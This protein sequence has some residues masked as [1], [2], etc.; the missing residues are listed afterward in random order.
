MKHQR[1]AFPDPWNEFFRYANDAFV[2]MNKELMRNTPEY[3][4]ALKAAVAARKQ[5]AKEEIRAELFKSEPFR[6]EVER[7]LIKE[8][9]EEQRK[10]V[11]AR[12]VADTPVVALKF[13]LKKP[14]I[15]L[16]E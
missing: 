9:L 12:V 3:T 8:I 1:L 10:D 13:T 5:Q 15:D 7:E 11:A 6:Y 16:L 2:R 14:V 4:E